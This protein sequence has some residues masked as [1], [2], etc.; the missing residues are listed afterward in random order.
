MVR[1]NSSRISAIF[2]TS[3]PTLHLMNMMQMLV[4]LTP[5]YVVSHNSRANYQKFEA[6]QVQGPNDLD[7]NDMLRQTQAL[8]SADVAAPFDESL[9]GA[10]ATV[11]SRM[12][13]VVNR[14]DHLVN[15]LPAEDF[16][17][18]LH[19]RLLELDSDCGHRAHTCEMKR[20]GKEVAAFLEE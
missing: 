12:L 20:I 5:Q 6:E 14:Q 18:M 17:R 10:A 2:G 9:R 3:E 8:L 13:V 4:L 15:P 11:R 19:A 16:A 1:S 7:A